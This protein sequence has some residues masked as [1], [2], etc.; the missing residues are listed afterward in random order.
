M[1]KS[2]THAHLPET[3][4]STPGLILVDGLFGSD[5]VLSCTAIAVFIIYLK[6]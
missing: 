3:P 6:K 5:S 2:V 4:I 1:A